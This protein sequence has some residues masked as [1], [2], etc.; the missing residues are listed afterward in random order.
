M[1]RP[2]LLAEMERQLWQAQNERDEALDALERA[3]DAA[4]Y[5]EAAL[6]EALDELADVRDRLA[7]MRHNTMRA[8]GG[9]RP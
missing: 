8:V 6:H 1:T 5:L 9:G 2:W 4:V 3:R 7:A